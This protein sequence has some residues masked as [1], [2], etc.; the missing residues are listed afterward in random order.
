[1][2]KTLKDLSFEDFEQLK[3]MG[4]LWEFYPEAPEF[5]SE[6]LNFETKNVLESSDQ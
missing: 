6:I 2:N 1:M 4:Y 3:R 5:Y